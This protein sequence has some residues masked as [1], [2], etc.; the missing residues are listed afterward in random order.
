VRGIWRIS[1]DKRRKLG[2]YRRI[3]K[4]T[5]MK[6]TQ[7][8]FGVL[9]SVFKFARWVWKF[10]FN[11]VSIKNCENVFWNVVVLVVMPSLA[12][13]PRLWT[14]NSAEQQF[15]IFLRKWWYYINFKMGDEERNTFIFSICC[16]ISSFIFNFRFEINDCDSNFF[17][18]FKWQHQWPV[19]TFTE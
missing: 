17:N 11:F 1:L 13:T 2:N 16:Q 4:T 5:L 14:L 12:P 9:C 10:F 19:Q 3:E 7:H 15:L 8:F 6:V 18:I